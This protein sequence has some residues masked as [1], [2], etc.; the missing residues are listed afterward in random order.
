MLE[1]AGVF[2]ALLFGLGA[3]GGLFDFAVSDDDED[4]EDDFLLDNE[5]NEQ[6]MVQTPSTWEDASTVESATGDVETVTTNGGGITIDDTVMSVDV[7]DANAPVDTTADATMV[8]TTDPLDDIDLSELDDDETNSEW[9]YNPEFPENLSGDEGD[10]KI[11]GR[12]EIDSIFAGAGD[13]TVTGLAGDDGL[14]GEDGNDTLIGGSGHDRLNG[15]DGDDALLGGIHSDTL[16]GL[17]GDDFADGGDDHDDIFGG[18]GNDHLIG[19]AGMDTIEGGNGNDLIDGRELDENGVDLDSSDMIDGGAGDDTVFAG[20]ADVITLGDGEDTVILG[21][22]IG[23]S[24]ENL[25]EVTDFSVSDDNIVISYEGTSQDA[26][27]VDVEPDVEHEDRYYIQLDGVRVAAVMSD[28]TFDANSVKL[29]P[30]E[31]I[32]IL[33]APKLSA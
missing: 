20:S 14:F 27:T 29:V 21:E 1:M 15:G 12:G 4:Q 13:D 7:A 30:S 25:I 2:A 33:D 11:E 6:G 23:A 17:N 31:S 8:G 16:L 22:W 5:A 26:P 28:E 32:S 19:G 9:G 18:D 3:M 10:N 24:P